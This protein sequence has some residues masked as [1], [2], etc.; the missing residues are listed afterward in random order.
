MYRK[1]HIGLTLILL[2]KC[3]VSVHAKSNSAD[4]L[5]ISTPAQVGMSE[6]KIKEAEKLFINAVKEGAVLG[7]QLL[8]ARK[9]KVVINAAGGLR[10]LE[11][12]L[13]MN[14]NSLLNLASNTKSLTAIA[15]LKLV[16]EGEISLDDFVSRYLPG[17]DSGFSSKIT[18]KHLLLHQA[19]YL[20]F[21]LFHNGLTPYSPEEPEAPSL[22][23]EAKELGLFGP[24][25]EPG[26]TFRYNN[27]GYNILAAIIEEVTQKKLNNY[28][29]EIFYEPLGM[30]ETVHLMSEVDSSRFAKQ[31]Y[32]YNGEWQLM[33][34][35]YPPIARGNGGTISNAWDFAKFFQMLVNKG[36][37]NNYKI[38]SE[39]IITEATSPLLEVSEAYLSE[40]IERELGLPD[41]EWYELRDPR[42][43]NIDKHRGYG[44]VVS[45]NGGF[46]HA[47]IYGTFAYAD[48]KNELVI[49]IFTQSIYGGN[50]G[51]MF[52]ET[53][54]DA[55]IK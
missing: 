40:E 37:Y 36:K 26:T 42:G 51:Q 2:I 12:N 3:F 33:D 21:E 6:A 47:G 5:V 23:V 11:N 34:S 1:V 53:I 38:L 19:G 10:D 32:F 4:T 24:E 30:T 27:Q 46:S 28:F 14:K 25:V 18:I 44:F 16:D 20:R 22:K 13:P 39:Q 29:E 31:Y 8:V 41:S 52:I 45:D 54:Y 35:S 17:F 7:Y 43:L 9:G 50:P 48:P 49:I 55:I 15:I